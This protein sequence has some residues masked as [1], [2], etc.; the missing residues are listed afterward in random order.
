[1]LIYW[2]LLPPLN[3]CVQPKYISDWNHYKLQICRDIYRSHIKIVSFNSL[4]WTHYSV[5]FVVKSLRL[6]VFIQQTLFIPKQY[7]RSMY[8]DIYGK[9]N[10]KLKPAY[11]A[12]IIL[13]F[14][15]YWSRKIFRKFTFRIW[16]RNIEPFLRC[17]YDKGIIWETKSV[18]LPPPA[19][20]F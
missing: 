13:Y 19:S 7:I 6:R 12:T 10:F 1:M 17:Y 5:G 11:G 16:K 4:L 15:Q 3:G 8:V 14:C 9:S 20:Y 18:F 2:L